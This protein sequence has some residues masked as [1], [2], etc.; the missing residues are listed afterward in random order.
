MNG[1]PTNPEPA[2]GWRCYF[3]TPEGLVL[4]AAESFASAE[5][6]SRWGRMILLYPAEFELQGPDDELVPA[7]LVDPEAGVTV[8]PAVQG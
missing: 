8:E 4:T 7:T 1:L 2:A 5:E 6:A 3:E